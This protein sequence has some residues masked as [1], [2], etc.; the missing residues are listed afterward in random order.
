[1]KQTKKLT[2][3]QRIFLQSKGYDIEGVR[4]CE[5]TN[6]YITIQYSN[7]DIERIDK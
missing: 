1:M 2:R 3:S 6:L 7:G 4:V 5:E